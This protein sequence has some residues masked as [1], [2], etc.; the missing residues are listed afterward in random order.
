MEF[1]QFILKDLDKKEMKYTY[2]NDFGENPYVKGNYLFIPFEMLNE[3]YQ[4]KFQENNKIEDNQTKIK[5][6]E[7]PIRKNEN[8][9][10]SKGNIDFNGKNEYC[11][12]KNITKNNSFEIDKGNIEKKNVNDDLLNQLSKRE[13]TGL[14]NIGG[15]CY[16]NAVLQCFYY[17]PPLT[18]YFLKIDNKE[19]NS[20]GLV[21]KGYYELVNGLS[22]GNSYAAKTFK[23][24]MIEVDDTFYGSEGKDSKDV[25]ILLL[26][27]LQNELKENEDS[28]LYLEQNVNHFNLLDVY[29][30]I[31]DLIIKNNNK[32]IITDTFNF[33]IKVEQTCSKICKN[34]FQTYYEIESEN[35]YIFELKNIYKSISQKRK[36]TIPE[37]S[38]EECLQYYKKEKTIKCPYCKLNTLKIKKVICSLPKIFIFVLSRGHN[39]EFNCKIKFQDSIDMK[40]YY[41]P[42][43]KSD[44]N[45][46]YKLICATFAI[47]WNYKGDGHTIAFCKTYKKNKYNE[48]EYYIFNDSNAYRSNMDIINN[49]IPYLLFYEKC[50]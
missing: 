43:N 34:F 30:E 13:P 20:L 41:E 14:V 15:V 12:D 5:C 9:K 2:L 28:I 49:K 45:T 46:K 33:F 36:N 32:T 26:D 19:K 16:M 22:K 39:I 50:S 29:K 7:N 10:A 21:T 42:I 38:L 48:N 23:K 18:N 35:I 25:A 24:A 27:E 37:I 3:K 6:D 47:D 1:I 11:F 17:C 31:K 4:K 40:S 44:T 8:I